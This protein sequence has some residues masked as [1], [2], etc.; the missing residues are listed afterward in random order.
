[1]SSG[2]FTGYSVS[3]LCRQ[4]SSLHSRLER[5]S[6]ELQEKLRAHAEEQHHL[7]EAVEGAQREKMLVERDLSAARYGCACVC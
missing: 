5:T 7:K 2:I 6:S 1:M 3:S 4:V